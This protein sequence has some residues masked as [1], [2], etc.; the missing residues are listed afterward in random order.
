MADALE[1]LVRK[2]L[3]DGPIVASIQYERADGTVVVVSHPRSTVVAR[4]LAA[5][6]YALLHPDRDSA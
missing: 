2:V 1:A 3:A 6:A 4:G 5:E